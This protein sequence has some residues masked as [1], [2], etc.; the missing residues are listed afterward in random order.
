MNFLFRLNLFGC[1]EF[2]L[3]QN[4][5]VNKIRKHGNIKKTS[6]VRMIEILRF[7]RRLFFIYPTK[8]HVSQTL[9]ANT[10]YHITVLLKCGAMKQTDLQK[11]SDFLRLIE[12]PVVRV[13]LGESSTSAIMYFSSACEYPIRFKDRNCYL[14]FN[15]SPL[16]HVVQFIGKK[17]NLKNDRNRFIFQKENVYE[18]PRSMLN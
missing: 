2:F 17:N 16:Q 5:V 6:V 7:Q 18:R 8:Q 1:V 10:V 4:P 12:T 11:H 14:Q 9:A 13:I 15:T 3:N